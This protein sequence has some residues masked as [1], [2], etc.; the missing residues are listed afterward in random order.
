MH[1]LVF[2]I[3]DSQGPEADVKTSADWDWM[4]FADYVNCRWIPQ[5][6]G[7]YELQFLVSLALISFL[8]MFQSWLPLYQTCPTHC[9]SVENLPD[10]RGYATSDLFIPH[11]TKPGLWKMC[12]LSAPWSDTY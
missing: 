5:G 9:P 1:T 8:H 7:T 4:R 12:V 2:D 10:V 6:D 11:P 3:D